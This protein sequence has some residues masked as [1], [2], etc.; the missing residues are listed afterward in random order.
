MMDQRQVR[1]ASSLHGEL[2]RFIDSIRREELVDDAAAECEL[3][4]AELRTLLDVYLNE[5]FLGLGLIERK[6]A[7][8]ARILEIGSGIG[9]LSSFLLSRGFDVTSVEPGAAGYGH[10]HALS[11]ALS[12]QV[13]AVNYRPLPIPAE[14][15]NV[16]E[17]GTFD[18][19][20]SVHVLE[21]ILEIERS[22]SAMAGVLGAEGRMVHICPNYTVPY[23]PHFGIPL[24]PFAP[25]AT[26]H[27]VRN[28]RTRYPG[29]WDGLNF[30]SARKVDRMAADNGLAVEFESGVM[31][32]F[33]RRL[34]RD[35]EFGSRQTNF[36]MSAVALLSRLGGQKI[37]DNWPARYATP[38]IFT[39]SHRRA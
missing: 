1:P 6:L 5:A 32:A 24:V 7:V 3:P 38:M 8:G 2:V 39:L 29:V 18:L 19:I 34:N 36:V 25:R 30:I 10:M 21:H 9:V 28:V 35:S 17:H 22:I 27:L 23:E 20:F 37:L 14:G 13:P 11:A 31:G 16:P 4:K 26:M 33:V 12:R 15:L